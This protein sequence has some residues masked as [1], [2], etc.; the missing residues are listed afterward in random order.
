MSRFKDFLAKHREKILYVLVGLGTTAVDW[1]LYAFFVLFVPPLKSEWLLKISPNFVAFCV[2]WLGAVVFSYV[3][4]RKFVFL[5]KE[6]NI[7]KEF[8]LFVCSRLFTLLISVAGD[9]LLCGNYALFPIKN[10]FIAKI[11][12][13][14]LIIIINYITGKLL[15]FK[16]R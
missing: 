1:A 12:V 5:S 3:L 2:A 10:P 6:R 11:I 9:I 14:V 15:V 7:K 4:S 13:S 8:F 16:K